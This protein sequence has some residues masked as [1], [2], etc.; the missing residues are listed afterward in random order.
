VSF[1]TTEPKISFAALPRITVSI[2]DFAYC[3]VNVALPV[4]PLID[5]EMVDVPVLRPC[6]RPKLTVATDLVDESHATCRVMSKV[7]P[8]LKFPVAANA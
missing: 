8:S 6:A 1:G 5:A 7:E 3:T 2:N 4:T